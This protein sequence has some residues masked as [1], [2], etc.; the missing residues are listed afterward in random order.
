MEALYVSNVN[1]SIYTY[2]RRMSMQSD[3]AHC[4]FQIV[5]YDASTVIAVKSSS[6][7]TALVVLF[8]EGSRSGFTLSESSPGKRFP[9]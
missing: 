9:P 2:M 7:A 6:A 3:V 5:T 1:V 8:L 4:F